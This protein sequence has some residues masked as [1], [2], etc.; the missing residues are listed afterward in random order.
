MNNDEILIIQNYL[1]DIF[2]NEDISV[3]K[4]QDV[5]P[6]ASIF[7]SSEAIG[8][9]QKDD[10]PDEE[11]ISYS[12]TIPIDHSI[13][14]KENLET[15]IQSLSKKKKIIISDRGSIED[16]KEVLILNEN[17]EEEFI[18]VVFRDNDASC[19][20]SMSILDFDL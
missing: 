16:S 2:D 9:L 5:P 8:G 18:G 1:R 6:T 10:D 13:T 15:N 17:D 20:F 3:R 11:D 7:I 4:D 19:T 12:L 14:D